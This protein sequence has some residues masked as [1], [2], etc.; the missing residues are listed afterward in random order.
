MKKDFKKNKSRKSRIKW[1]NVITIIMIIL[2]IISFVKHIE[3]NGFYF[4]LIVEVILDT[5]IVFTIRY[6]INEMIKEGFNFFELFD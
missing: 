5:L 3:L 6:C 1:N 4:G 2:F